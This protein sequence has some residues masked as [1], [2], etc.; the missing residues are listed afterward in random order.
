M[1]MENPQTGLDPQGSCSGTAKSEAET[2]GR[3]VERQR[4][5]GPGWAY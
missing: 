2:E 5:F 3:A 4:A 1:A